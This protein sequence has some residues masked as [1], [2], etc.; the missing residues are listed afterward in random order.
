MSNRFLNAKICDI[1]INGMKNVLHGKLVFQNMNRLI[2]TGFENYRFQHVSGMYGNNGSGKSTVVETMAFLRDLIAD[3][4]ILG[5]SEKKERMDHQ[6]R[7]LINAETKDAQNKFTVYLKKEKEEIFLEYFVQIKKLE[8]QFLIVSEK[9]RKKAKEKDKN[10]NSWKTMLEYNREQ[11]EI[12]LDG[13]K[14]KKNSILFTKLMAYQEQREKTDYLK[15]FFFD[16]SAY[17]LVKESCS[18]GVQD[19]LCDLLEFVNYDLLTLEYNQLSELDHWIL[20]VA[21]QFPDTHKH[22]QGTLPL[23]MRPGAKLTIPIDLYSSVVNVIAQI[24]TVLQTIIPD[25]DLDLK[26]VEKTINEDGEPSYSFEI[27]SRRHGV[28][29]PLMHESLGIKKI[30]S[31]LNMLVACYNDPRINLFIDEMDSGVFEHLLGQ[32]VEAFD[33]KA[34]GF[35]FFTA[36]NLRPLEKIEDKELYFTTIDPN[37]RY[38][39]LSVAANNNP[40]NV[41]FHDINLGN[42]HG[43]DLADIPTVAQIKLGFMKAGKIRNG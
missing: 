30:I 20:P 2:K 28:E 8:K 34:K 29:I 13:R 11:D 27:M 24:H 36:H 40:R 1:E 39:K 37:E 18:E 41:Y 21:I 16:Q 25:L 32:L 17:D 19:T 33:Q 23:I 15:S 12:R 26:N 9:I 38:T 6:R 14:Q 42:D 35:L 5:A 3:E 7:L 4:K 31:M 43:P 10:W 22:L